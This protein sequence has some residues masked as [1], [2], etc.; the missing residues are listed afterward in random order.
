MFKT[1]HL[2]Y[3]MYELFDVVMMNVPGFHR[4]FG[5]FWPWIDPFFRWN[6]RGIGQ[7]AMK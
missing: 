2:T 7:G 6:K 3:G 1:T 5:S 4:A